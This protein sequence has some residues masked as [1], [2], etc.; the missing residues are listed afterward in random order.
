MTKALTFRAVESSAVGKHHDGDGLYL[1]VKA[2]G[3]RSWTQRLTIKGRRTEIGL[4]PYPEITLKAARELSLDARRAALKGD[5]PAGRKNRDKA[6]IKFG[7]FADDF[8]AYRRKNASDGNAK[9]HAQ[10]S[11]TLGDAYCASIR[12]KPVA[13][14]TTN[15]ILVVLEPIWGTKR[16]TASR[17]RQR[18]EAV[19]NAAKVKGL[20]AGDNPARLKGHLDQ[21]LGKDKKQGGHHAALPFS[22]A[23]AFMNRLRAM[24]DSMAARALEFTI[25]TA[26]RTSEALEA[27]WEEINFAERRW[28]VP[29][30]RTKTKVREH[31]VPLSDAA[32]AV[33][34]TVQGGVQSEWI[35]P[36]P[37]S[38]RSAPLSNMAMAAVVKRMGFTG[39]GQS[40][41]TV[42][43]F[44]STFSDWVSETG[45]AE[46]EVREMAL[47]HTVGNK[48]VRAYRRGDL[49][50]QRIPLMTKW[51]DFLANSPTKPAAL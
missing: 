6:P 38:Q 10:W 37:Q 33:L 8:V 47:S 39:K 40:K 29:P 30:I 35:F 3:A 1:L 27:R 16:E 41:A 50:E 19:L 43:G 20:F 32:L 9:H 25:L 49:Y 14:I 2:S 21:Y 15:D 46:F 22:Q 36:S 5:S 24:E 7:A 13:E 12:K 44:R 23:P 45:V 34:R 51:A 42:H 11:M 17:I 4:G 18:I 48:V 31:K 28:T 26:V